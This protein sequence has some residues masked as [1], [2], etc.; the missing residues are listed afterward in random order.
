MSRG[1]CRRQIPCHHLYIYIYICIYIYIKVCTHTHT[2]LGSWVIWDQSSSFCRD[3]ASGKPCGF[4]GTFSHS[5]FSASVA[6]WRYMQC[7]KQ[8]PLAWGLISVLWCFDGAKDLCGDSSGKSSM[9]VKAAKSATAA[10]ARCWP[11]PMAW[12]GL[13]SKLS[14]K[15]WSAGWM[16]WDCWQPVK[17]C[18]CFPYTNNIL[19]TK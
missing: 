19:N 6:K 15:T 11:L 16:S 3:I 17:N 1:Q 12:W 9:Q 13:R 18:Y 2:P 7:Q 4:R 14:S 5:S 8:R 10:L